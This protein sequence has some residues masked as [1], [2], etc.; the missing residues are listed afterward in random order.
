MIEALFS[1]IFEVLF[2]WILSY[3]GA[4]VRWIFTKNKSFKEIYDDNPYWNGG[5]GILVFIV[6]ICAILVILGRYDKN[7]E[8]VITMNSVQIFDITATID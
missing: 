7:S 3:P 1:L 6:V 4:F 8:E 2:Y 5:I